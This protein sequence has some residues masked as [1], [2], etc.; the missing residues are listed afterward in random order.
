VNLSNY[1]YFRTEN[2]VLY[3]GDCMEIMPMLEPV[4][5]VLTDPP[6]G[7][8]ACGWDTCIPFGPMWEQL[9]RTAQ[10][11]AAI[12]LF[13]LQP[14]TSALVMSNPKMFKYEW[15]WNKNNSSGFATAKHRPFQICEHL[16]VF[17]EGKIKY[18][19]QM[20]TRSKP[21]SKGGYSASD[22]YRGLV[23]SR[24]KSNTYYPKNLLNYGN[25]VNKGK[26]H[27]TQKPVA[28]M[29]YIIKTYTNEAETVL[30]FTVGSGTTG[31]ACE[32]LGL[33]WIGIEISEKY[34]E[35]AKKR[36][37]A[38]NRQVKMFI[39]AIAP[40]PKHHPMEMFA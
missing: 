24:S 22:N 14:F 35:V 18:Y 32:R 9:K 36:I 33:K 23:P 4:D 16:L 2:G 29:E 38:E 28:L 6:Y 25:S 31:V 34:C 40:T 39:P 27:P 7:T 26:L 15:V 17:G 19:P 10:K 5:L 12:V 21:R 30:D 11:N 20:E 37:E 8:T 13:G 1:E 3:C